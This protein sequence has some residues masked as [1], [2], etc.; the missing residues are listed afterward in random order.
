MR[1]YDFYTKNNV[2][3]PW[4]FDFVGNVVFCI[5]FS[6][7]LVFSRFGFARLH[8]KVRSRP[9]VR[10]FVLQISFAGWSFEFRSQHFRSHLYKVYFCSRHFVRSVGFWILFS[11]IL[12]S[13]R[14]GGFS[15]SEFRSQRST[16][17]F[18]LSN[19]VLASTRWIFVLRIL[20]AA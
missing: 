9:K 11:A 7:L 6:A 20:F 14:Q 13:H 2:C 19:F 8:C 3:H 18:V 10:I 17:N 1:Y 12:F 5:S 4:D 16:L 15:F